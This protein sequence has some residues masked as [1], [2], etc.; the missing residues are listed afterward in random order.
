MR[1]AVEALENLRILPSAA[2]GSLVRAQVLK[3]FR[4]HLNSRK[5]GKPY[6]V[7]TLAQRSVHVPSA[8]RTAMLVEIGAEFELLKWEC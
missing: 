6:L 7:G 4:I 5:Y 8:S 2:L 3:R 1:G